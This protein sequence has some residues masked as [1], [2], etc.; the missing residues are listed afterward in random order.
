[1][2]QLRWVLGC[3]AQRRTKVPTDTIIPLPR[4]PAYYFHSVEVLFKF[5]QVLDAGKLQ[6][7]LDRLLGIGN[8][9]QLGGRLRQRENDRSGES[10]D[11]HVPA[12]F[13]TDR[14]G[15]IYK[16][17]SIDSTISNDPVA[18]KIPAAASGIS[19][20]PFRDLLRPLTRRDALPRSADDWIA[21]DY[22]AL[23]FEQ[24]DF[25]DASVIMVMFPHHLMDATGY[26]IF[27]RSWLAVLHGRDADVLPLTSFS[28][29]PID[30]MATGTPADRYIWHSHLVR[31]PG[32]LF[33][34]IKALWEALWGKEER[35]ICVPGR[36]LDSMREDAL[37]DLAVS[38]TPFNPSP[39]PSVDDNAKLK[40]KVQD[41]AVNQNLSTFVSHSDVLVAWFTRIAVS[42]SHQSGT[43]PLVISNS[44]DIRPV[45]SLSNAAY[46]MNSICAAYTMLPIAT[47]ISKPV[48]Y[49]AARLR[50][51]LQVERTPEQIAARCAWAKKAGLTAAIGS[52]NMLHFI[53]TNWN[54]GG[55]FH[56]D[57]APAVVPQCRRRGDGV[58]PCS[59]DG[60][61]DRGIPCTPSGVFS[62]GPFSQMVPNCGAILGR[63]CQNNWWMQ[64]ILPKSVWP[65]I[66]R[67][68]QA[69]NS[70]S[71]N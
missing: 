28:Y 44:F 8:W 3:P 66:E 33:V 18:S 12:E 24:I 23:F 47:A 54:K 43:T 25:L 68:L 11:L 39:S 49:L 45:C 53:L 26:A 7:A 10:Y 15:Y 41:K 69:I 1:M 38:T 48:S 51:S 22:P 62:I 4:I 2:D 70:G 42:A 21:S 52:P 63:D 58:P 50:M 40:D 64:W 65:E 56:L 55:Y 6:G 32:L 60:H 9:R 36:F 57:F 19:I 30:A 5:D 13:T 61:L 46:L 27:L 16:T 20:V 59:S 37:K 29:S 31:W 34:I 71:D 14:P 17:S 67:H 35:L